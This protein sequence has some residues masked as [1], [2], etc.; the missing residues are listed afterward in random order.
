MLQ[1]IKPFH[2]D[3]CGLSHYNNFSLLY[4]LFC[5]HQIKYL[6]KKYAGE[7]TAPDQLISKAF[8]VLVAYITVLVTQSIL[9]KITNF[10]SQEKHQTSI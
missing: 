9:L 3:L 2:H 5:S 7:W 6:K 4:N 10:L 8:N 1:N